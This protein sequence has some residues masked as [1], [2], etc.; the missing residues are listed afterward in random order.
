MVL[1]RVT[2]A[3]VAMDVDSFRL[4]AENGV[5]F[6]TCT[7]D[8]SKSIVEEVRSTDHS[9]LL[10]DMQRWCKARSA[11]TML[12]LVAGWVVLHRAGCHDL[13][14]SETLRTIKKFLTSYITILFFDVCDESLNDPGND[15]NLAMWRKV[16]IDI[17]IDSTV[18]S[19]SGNELRR[20]AV[21]IVT[22]SGHIIGMD[23]H[24]FVTSYLTCYPEQRL[25]IL[26]DY[27]V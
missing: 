5:Y 18:S 26:P 13:I 7:I 12:R 11:C 27:F 4:S 21:D 25:E 24:Y 2:C 20:S 17:S 8:D 23:N 15:A 3:K 16:G 6:T 14:D 19:I 22:G 9:K 1:E 10:T